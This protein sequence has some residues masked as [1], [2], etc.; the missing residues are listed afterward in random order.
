MIAKGDNEPKRAFVALLRGVNVSG[1]H[2][3]PMA[4]L[5]SI[6]LRVGCDD[7]RTYIQSGNVVVSAA[8]SAAALEATLEHAIRR[9]FGFFVPVIVRSAQRWKR[10]VSS[11]PFQKEAEREANRVLLAL[12]KQRPKADAVAKLRNYAVAAEQIDK[13]ND[14]VWI[15]Y[16][17][18]IARSKLTPTVLDRCVGSPVT[19]RNWR[20]V[21]RLTE[22]L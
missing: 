1:R 8:G 16:P 6:C 20:T 17:N 19:A 21:L 18:G 11:T 15:Y 7:A 10:Y 2:K 4:Q 5:R 13:R 3:V 22:M 12:S 9:E 14:G